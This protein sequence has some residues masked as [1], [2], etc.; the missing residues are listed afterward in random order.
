MPEGDAL[1][2]AAQ[3]LQV[4]VGERL[5]VEAPNPRAAV[6]NIAPRLDGRRL[7]SVEAVGK[8]LFLRFEGPITLRSHLRM[9]GRWRVQPRG[10]TTDGQPWL[11]LRGS[12]H[13]AVLWHG[14]VLELTDA[15]RRRLGPDILAE[16]PDVDAMLA[17]LRSLPPD[18]RL[19]E[20]LQVQRAVAGIGNMWASEA[21]FEARLSPWL[22]LR[23][24]GDEELRRALDAAAALM[25]GRLAAPRRSPHRVYRRKGR[26][27][28]RCGGTIRSWPLGDAART[29]YWCPDCQRGEG[30][31]AE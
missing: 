11:V 14:P 15:V 2:R 3:R 9:K 23:E 25:H 19:G 4:L 17:N 13:E 20:A 30:P 29:A 27:C 18:T 5:E 16:S 31:Q 7:E 12:R 21:L 8:N 1:A 26:P 28:P 6:K 10:R 22:S 24:A